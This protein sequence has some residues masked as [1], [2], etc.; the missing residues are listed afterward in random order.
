[1]KG[2]GD[3]CYPMSLS[4]LSKVTQL[5]IVKKQDSDPDSL[6]PK[7]VCIT[8]TC[9][10]IAIS[11]IQTFNCLGY[12]RHFAKKSLHSHRKDKLYAN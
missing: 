1:M 5:L 3:L 7:S 6:A 10:P 4:N 9:F 11:F 2:K 8:T 12:V